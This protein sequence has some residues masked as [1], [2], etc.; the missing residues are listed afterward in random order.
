[1]KKIL[2]IIA[3]ILTI[4]VMMSVSLIP[5]FASGGLVRERETQIH[6]SSASRYETPTYTPTET[7]DKK[8][9]P[10]LGATINELNPITYVIIAIGIFVVAMGLG[11]L[12]GYNIKKKKLKKES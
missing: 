3:I 1:M 7:P 4:C 8:A 12:M 6:T 11:I 9:S 2:S 5:A 10:L